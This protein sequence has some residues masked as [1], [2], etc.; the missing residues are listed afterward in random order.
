MVS[1][2]DQGVSI[3]LKFKKQKNEGWLCYEI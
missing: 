2:E 3:I 1:N